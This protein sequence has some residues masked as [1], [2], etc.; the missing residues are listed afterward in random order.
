MAAT[1]LTTDDLAALELCL[2]AMDEAE[3][4]QAFIQADEEFHGIIVA[5]SG[6]STLASL[7]QFGTNS[8]LNFGGT[9]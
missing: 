8:R 9:K 4:T 2:A 6:N 1:R 3:T 7:I 5:A